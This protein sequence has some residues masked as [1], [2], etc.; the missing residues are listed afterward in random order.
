MS[1]IPTAETPR[2]E[3]RFSHTLD[4]PR[5]RVFAAW[6]DPEQF[7]GWFGAELKVPSNSVTLDPRAG[8]Q[9]SATMI[10]GPTRVPFAGT[11]LE[12]KT[13]QRIVMTFDD[14]DD[15]GTLP[16]DE[17]Q[18]LTVTFRN[19]GARTE[20]QFHQVGPMAPGMADGL[21]QGYTSF[22]VRLGEILAGHHAKV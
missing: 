18:V 7:A 21:T 8:G 22:M 13:P 20:L 6:T 3:M 2:G 17:I 15:V 10:Q 4:A 9:W 14:P 12:V 11:Y 16:T 19:L 5:D 1:E